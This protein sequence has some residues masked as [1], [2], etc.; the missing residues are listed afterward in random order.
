MFPITEE[1][2]EREYTIAGNHLILTSE[3]TANVI[4]QKTRKVLGMIKRGVKS[5]E[6]GSFFL[7]LKIN[8]LKNIKI[9]PKRKITLVLYSEQRKRRRF[10]WE[11]KVKENRCCQYQ[12]KK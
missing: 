6:I 11:V 8:L 12:E 9:V 1:Y 5:R 7:L 3:H 4:Q 10:L 2:I